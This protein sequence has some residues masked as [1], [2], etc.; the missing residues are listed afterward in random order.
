MRGLSYASKGVVDSER[1]PSFDAAVRTCMPRRISDYAIVGDTRTAALVDRSGSIDWLCLPR[2]DS[3]A[4]F[5]ALL[6]DE[7][8]GRW[9]MAPADRAERTSRRYRPDT[10]VLET[11]F[12]TA[13]GVVRVV[14]CM[15]PGES[16]PN[17]VRQVEGVAGEVKMRM[18]LAIR[19]DY[20]WIVPWVRRANGVLTAT[21]GPDALALHAP[22]DTHGEGMTTVAEFTVRAGDRLPF[23]LSWYRS[24]EE[25]PPAIEGDIV[26]DAERW[27]HEWS[28]ACHHAGRWREAVVR[29]LI[30]LK[31][32][33][34]APTGGIVA[35]AT[36]SLPEL[37]GGVRNWD[38]RYCWLRDATFTLY[39]LMLGGYREEAGAWRDWLL[40]AAAG[41]PRQ[42]QIMYGVMGERRLPE[43][44]LGWLPGFRGS[45]PVRIGNAAAHQLQLDV[46][47]EVSDALFQA[48]KAGIEPEPLAW[49]L[50]CEM[51]E[52]LEDAW[53]EPDAGIW[54]V[55]GP[56]QHFTH[57]KIMCW[58]AFDRAV[59]TVR[60][61]GF[62]A[63][64]ERWEALRDAVHD[65]VCTRGYNRT[66]KAFTQ[67]YGAKNLDASLLMM[68][69]VGFLPATDERIIGTVRAIEH[70]LIDHGLVLRYRT[71]ETR[72]GLPAG[73][74]AFLACSFWLADNYAL[75]GRRQEAEALF[76]QLL[77]LRNDVGLL[78][79][80]VEPA[81]GELLG[82]FPQAFSHVGLVNTAFNLTPEEPA[83][84]SE[85]EKG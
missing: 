13:D 83:P 67:T 70:D 52:F 56:A 23:V 78:S 40:R 66:R 11:E 39:A 80:E 35:A 49:S 9:L 5:A 46:Y 8:N 84:V 79:E 85:R 27:W 4:C 36:T 58:V 59:K 62:D 45:T 22:V 6:G 55:R 16:V 12:A 65:E 68:A 75:M 71:D 50:Q 31:A 51:L 15:P 41:A 21:G 72:D 77:A 48:R 47:G 30:T 2:F 14:D 82:N 3:G 26:G 61:F 42:L 34:F 24:H 60:R 44:T 73:E 64:V 74:G 38:Y 69:P 29:S 63:P 20:G 33:T 76:E 1:E 28:R 25:V 32:L 37:I 81:T 17:I 57:S 19:F 18:D 53:R 43:M 7:R 10:L 54:E